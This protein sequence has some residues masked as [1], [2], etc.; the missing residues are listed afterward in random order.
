MSGSHLIEGIWCFGVV[1]N[2]FEQNIKKGTKTNQ[3]GREEKK[4]TKNYGVCFHVEKYG[5][6]TGKKKFEKKI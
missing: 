1:N 2:M 5:M 4:Q 3:W 6:C